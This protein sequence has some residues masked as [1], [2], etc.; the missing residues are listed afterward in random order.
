MAILNASVGYSQILFKI[1][2]NPTILPKASSGIILNSGL[3]KSEETGDFEKSD[4]VIGF[5]IVIAVGPE[6]K[7]LEAGDAIFFDRRSVRPVP[8]GQETWNV[9]EQNTISYVKGN[10]PSLIAAFEEYEKATVEFHNETIDFTT[11]MRTS[12]AGIIT[13][14][15]NES[16]SGKL[17][18]V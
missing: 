16:G 8:T 2:P 5:G 13:D 17:I 6:C 7:F 1:V 15:T 3:H 14:S 12:N 18:M 11:R 9:S 4:N 10:D